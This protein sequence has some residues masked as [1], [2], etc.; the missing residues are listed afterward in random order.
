MKKKNL[1]YFHRRKDTGEVF[2]VGIGNRKRPYKTKRRS[3]F[4]WNIVNKVGY[5]IEIVHT[6]L[7]WK[8]ACKLERHYI[9]EFGRRDLGLGNL[10]NLTDGGDGHKNPSKQERQRRKERAT[11]NKYCVGREVSQETR[12]LLS[13]LMKGI[14]RHT[15]EFKEYMSARMSGEGNPGYGKRGENSITGWYGKK[16]TEETKKKIAEGNKGKVY[17]DE[18]RK[19]ISEARMGK[20]SWNKGMIMTYRNGSAKLLEEQVKSIRKEYAEGN[21]THKKLAEK[22]DCSPK[23]IGGIVRGE[24]WKHLL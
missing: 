7:T 5:D 15:E 10:V 11:G 23:T 17:S 4:W 13:D 18:T 2:Y 21:T 22:Y 16:H 9:K 3:E 19:K 14:P 1:V 12:Q 24:M 6:G 20:P 8:Q